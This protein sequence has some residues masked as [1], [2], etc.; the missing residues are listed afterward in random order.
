MRQA[1]PARDAIMLGARSHAGTDFDIGE[2]KL[3]NQ[4]E[5][6]LWQPGNKYA[7]LG[8]W[9]FHNAATWGFMRFETKGGYGKGY[10][11]EEWHWSYWP[12]AQALL[13][14][15]RQYQAAMEQ[16]LHEHWG[17]TSPAAEFKFVWKAWRD[18]LNNVDE[19]P[20]F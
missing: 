4:L 10:M 3:K 6:S 12:V 18:F 15:A 9:L 1:A 20:R 11:P 2:V 13:D 16:A 14:F 17:G 19:T 7:D 8:R 5:S